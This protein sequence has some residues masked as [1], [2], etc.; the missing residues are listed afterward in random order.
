MK[1]FWFSHFYNWSI[2]N[3]YNDFSNDLQCYSFPLIHVWTALS[4]FFLNTKHGTFTNLQGKKG[5]NIHCSQRLFGMSYITLFLQYVF[6]L[7]WTF[8]F[9]SLSYLTYWLQIFLFFLTCTQNGASYLEKAF[10][11]F[12]LH[13]ILSLCTSFI[14]VIY[15]CIY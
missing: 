9:V 7:Y 4:G 3:Q 2:P 8:S 11:Y 13:N 1:E 10:P 14:M 12:F 6:G 15:I 5:V